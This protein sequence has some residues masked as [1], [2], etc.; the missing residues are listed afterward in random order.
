MNK[1]VKLKGKLALYSRW[2]AILGIIL[3]GF[4]IFGTV[5]G[6]LRVGAYMVAALIV[7]VAA[8]TVLYI[9]MVK[10]VQDEMT[11]F[12]MRFSGLQQNLVQELD[13]PYLILN[14]RGRI[15]WMNNLMQDLVGGS[16]NTMMIRTVLP[17]LPISLLKDLLAGRA[18]DFEGHICHNETYY[19]VL[20]QPL[21]FDQEITGNEAIEINAQTDQYFS[22][23]LYDETE[24]VLTRKEIANQKAICGIILVDNYE[25]ALGSI[26][27]VR[28]S[29]LSALVDRKI[30]K[31]FQN[32]DAVVTKTEKDRFI[33][34]IR[35]QYLPALQTSKFS[36]LDEVREINIGNE[37]PVTLCIGMGVNASSYSQSQEWARHA[38]DLALGRGGDQAVIK[39]HD[40]L[41]YYG[42]KTKHVEKSTR[43]R[44]RVK[45]HALR[46]VIEGRSQVVIMGHKIGDVDCIGAA[47]GVYRAARI[48][49]K[50]AYIVLNDVTTSVQPILDYFIGNSE[51]DQGMFITSE[52]AKDIVNN[53]TA[54]IIVDVSNAARVEGPELLNLTKTVVV[55][56]H[57][58]QNGSAIENP[59]LAY[60]EPYASSAC[61][62]VTEIL[63]Y[64]SDNVKLRPEE[65][66][67]LYAG[68]LIDTDHFLNNTGVR[69]FEAAAYLRRCGADI[70]RVR[71]KLRDTFS[72][73]K[74]KAEAVKDAS[75]EEGYAFAICP[76]EGIKS[77]TVLGAEIANELLNV[78][79]VDAS[80]VFTEMK[81]TVYISA[82]SISSL[83]V[84]LVMEKLGGGGHST[85][86][87]AQLKDASISD[88]IA[89]VKNV[90]NEMKAEGEIN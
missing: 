2:P 18:D 69:T 36:I 90:L 25:E 53:N 77:P 62:M 51:Y 5:H 30:T 16:T 52:T 29:L 61:E 3:A 73:Y 83:N 82:R 39:D 11:D 63:Q 23:Y 54:L 78:K 58:R 59:V 38:L 66:D 50:Q 40:K 1:H 12:A 75:I 71:I 7:Y 35:S 55:I 14:T 65:A 33:F 68:I 20:V 37:L 32:Y 87:G 80:F 34:V 85:I 84:Q 19:K 43:V 56:D 89:Q 8:A 44:A 26:E 60:I 28:Q 42:G 10:N 24:V 81:G 57:H 64:I 70:S 86:A 41:S 67:A 48:L 15:I 4:T 22:L 49:N 72:T 13:V 17:E 31:Y 45:A 74:A 88:A 47:I 9:Y 46:Q 76:S 6:G 27:D 79:D 21:T